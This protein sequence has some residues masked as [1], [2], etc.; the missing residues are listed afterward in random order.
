LEYF[1]GAGWRGLW[2]SP[3]KILSVN[4]AK[5]LTIRPEIMIYDNGSSNKIG[6]VEFNFGK[7]V[8]AGIQFQY[9]F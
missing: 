9:T 1:L 6:G 5:G 2:S 3:R 7:E 8:L 4:L